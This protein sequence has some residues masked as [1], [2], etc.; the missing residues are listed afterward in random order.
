[1]TGF[2]CTQCARALDTVVHVE[3]Y[4]VSGVLNTINLFHFQID[5]GIDHIVGENVTGGEELAICVQ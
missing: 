5:V 4:W 2:R 1:M 3:L